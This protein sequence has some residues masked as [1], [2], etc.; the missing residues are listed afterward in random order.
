MAGI[1]G[2]AKKSVSTSSHTTAAKKSSKTSKSSGPSAAQAAKAKKLVEVE[3]PVAKPL[4]DLPLPSS[5]PIEA[6]EKIKTSG[7]EGVTFRLDGGFLDSLRLQCRRITDEHGKPGMIL[8]LKI[9]GPSRQTFQDQLEKKGAVRETFCFPGAE[10]QKKKS[11]VVLHQNGDT[12]A[13]HSYF[14]SYDD[15]DLGDEPDKA[16]KLSG[17]NWKLDYVPTEG[18]IAL[19]GLVRLTLSG[20]DAECSAALKDAIQKTGLQPAFAPP[21]SATLKRYAMMKLLWHLAPKEAKSLAKSGNLSS[22]K[23]ET[24]TQALKKHGVSQ[25]RIDQLRYE[26]VAPGHFTVY[27]EH[28]AEEIK[29]AGLRFCYSTVTSPDHVLSILTNGQKATVTRWCEGAFIQGMSSME[30]VGSGGAQGVFSRLV[31]DAAHGESWTGRTYKIILKP[32]L[33]GRLDIWGWPDDQ[34]GQSWDLTA[35][36]F[37]VKLLED[38][39]IKDSYQDYNEIV[40]PVGNGPQWIA[41][42][43]ATDEY[44]RK[45][46]I[47]HLEK[48]GWKPPHG[49]KIENFVLLAPDIKANLLGGKAPPEKKDP[50]GW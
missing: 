30:D 33:M 35:S 15:P 22:L 31:T 25:A 40:S 24:I 17:N 1:G 42:V 29:K 7:P 34:F 50:Y 8:D 21:T 38:V 2:V 18:P 46:L 27:D 23:L 43:V 49:K 20:S 12:H 37:G 6:L 44:S 3:G 5:F 19:R 32:E 47:Q 41:A 26:E 13:L 28:A 48:E 14:G 11:Q 9:A 39:G 36:N 10:P 45:K 4:D 16:L